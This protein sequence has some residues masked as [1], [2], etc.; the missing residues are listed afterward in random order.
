MSGMSNQA[1]PGE[2]VR[3]KKRP[4]DLTTARRML[5]LVQRIV[6]DIV[7][8]AQELNKFTFEQE[9]LD[10]NKT[11]LSWPERQ[12]RYT[13]QSEVDRLKSRLE[14]EKREL[15]SL[16][17]VLFNPPTVGLIGFPT[18]INDRPA[19][20]S[21]RLGE[22][23]LKYWH[24]EGEEKSRELIPANLEESASIRVVNQN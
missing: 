11:D 14:E 9:G 10:R 5:P 18:T 6:V 16:G 23:G 24:F 7:H 12:R 4:V 8:D 19:Y 15:D 13:V 17:A 3:R 22:E 20:F 1:G 21:W 2:K